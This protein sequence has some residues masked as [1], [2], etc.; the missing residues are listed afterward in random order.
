MRW[1]N[2]GIAQITDEG[3]LYYLRDAIILSATREYRQYLKSV[4]RA[5]AAIKE[6]ISEKDYTK[7]RR[8]YILWWYLN[9]DDALRFLRSDWYKTLTDIDGEY[10]IKKLREETPCGK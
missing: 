3:E 7:F 4:Q 2:Q 5:E 6:A 9:G 8:N 1:K 10:V